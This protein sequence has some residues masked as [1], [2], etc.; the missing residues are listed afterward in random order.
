MEVFEILDNINVNSIKG[1]TCYIAPQYQALGDTFVR[2]A[3]KILHENGFKQAKAKVVPKVWATNCSMDRHKT[4]IDIQFG[5]EMFRRTS[6]PDHYSSNIY[7]CLKLID[8]E[9]WM[10]VTIAGDTVKK[11]AP[12]VKLSAILL[13]E[14][15]HAFAPYKAG[16]NGEFIYQYSCLWRKYFDYVHQEIKKVL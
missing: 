3:T 15:A 10:T 9:N 8:S 14:V 12:S 16:H 1:G 5:E 11:L 4:F 6:T 7:Y 13:E 2:L